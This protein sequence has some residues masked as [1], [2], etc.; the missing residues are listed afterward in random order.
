[1]HI[2][3]LASPCTSISDSNADLTTV[4]ERMVI[5][6]I[7][8]KLLCGFLAVSLLGVSLGCTGMFSSYLFT[9]STTNLRELSQQEMEFSQI[10]AAHY[11]WRNSLS[12]SVISGEPFTGTL[13]PNPSLTA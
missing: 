8:L 9:K 13:D 10:L 3:S 6:S 12:E 4:L 7:R 11:N 5:V 1:M 2:Y